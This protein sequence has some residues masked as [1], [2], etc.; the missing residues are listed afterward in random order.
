VA[1]FIRE[2]YDDDD[3]DD[4]DVPLD[5]PRGSNAKRPHPEADRLR[6]A[7]SGCTVGL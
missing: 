5:S 4:D 2:F 3:D 1:T 7:A 6:A